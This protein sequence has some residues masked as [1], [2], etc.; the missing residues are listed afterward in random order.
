MENIK[1]PI[2]TETAA[3]N[4]K[5]VFGDFDFS[6]TIQSI[7]DGKFSPDTDNLI[8]KLA[9]LFF[10]ELKA[11]ERVISHFGIGWNFNIAF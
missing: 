3:E 1:E 8:N 2:I 5:Q 9:G 4:I 11:R 10:G 6:S 7:V